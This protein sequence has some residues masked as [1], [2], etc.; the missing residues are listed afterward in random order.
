MPLAPT[1]PM[2]VTPLANGPLVQLAGLPVGQVS[3]SVAS[4]AGVPA[5]R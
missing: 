3:E 4:S 5:P 1:T 2:L